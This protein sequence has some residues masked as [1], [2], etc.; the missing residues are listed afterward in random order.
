MTLS[1]A[2]KTVL[3][4][5]ANRGNG[6][7]MVRQLKARGMSGIGTALEGKRIDL[8]INNAGVG[9]QRAAS[10]ANY[11]IDKMMLTF[12]VN[13]IG[14]MRVTQALST[15]LQAG[16]HKTIVSISSVMG[17][18]DDNGKLCDYQREDIPW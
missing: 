12:D 11:D 3:V 16:Q 2:A 10:L 9:S 5:G 8:L 7:E 18:T 1:I 13:S 17:S 4:T 14:P 6:L 15:N